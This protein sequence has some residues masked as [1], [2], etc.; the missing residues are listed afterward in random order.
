MVEEA[1][2]NGTWMPPPPGHGRTAPRVDLSKKPRMWDLYLDLNDQ[3][4]PQQSVP[5]DERDWESMKP[6]MATYVYDPIGKINHASDQIDGAGAG[7]GAAGAT[8]GG[9]AA[10]GIDTGQNTAFIRRVVRSIGTALNP[11]PSRPQFGQSAPTTNYMGTEQ[12]QMTDLSGSRGPAHI[13]VAVLIAM[14][15]RHPSTANTASPLISRPASSGSVPLP[16]E[17]EEELPLIEMGVA[18]L[19]V[20]DSTSIDVHHPHLDVKGKM[21]ESIASVG[22]I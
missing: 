11:T 13:R 18:E 12:Q 3:L 21:R 10:G 2:R 4:L 1:I 5:V 8:S 7:L 17:D 16:N 9:G 15:G 20:T 22:S 14:P 19:M 6:L